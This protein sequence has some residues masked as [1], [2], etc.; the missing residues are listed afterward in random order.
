MLFALAITPHFMIATE[1]NKAED[2]LLQW[3]DETYAEAM[4]L[5]RSASRPCWLTRLL[6]KLD[7]S[8]MDAHTTWE[9]RDIYEEIAPRS[10][11]SDDLISAVRD[12]KNREQMRSGVRHVFH[13]IDTSA[14]Y[15]DRDAVTELKRL[16]SSAPI[17]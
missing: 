14:P 9:I 1:W 2:T 16:L 7:A 13:A 17:L 8:T 15:I 5:I 6:M 12:A 11:D 10:F 3:M 4:K